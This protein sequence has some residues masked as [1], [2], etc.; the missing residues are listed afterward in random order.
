MPFTVT[1][2]VAWYDP[3]RRLSWREGGEWPHPNHFHFHESVVAAHFIMRGYHVLRDCG[4]TRDFDSGRPLSVHSTRLLHDVVGS[5][6]TEF[7]T[8]E[9]A[10]ATASGTGEPDLFVFR[11]EHPNDPKYHYDDPRLWFFV[12]VKGPEDVVSEDQK[13]FWHK[14]AE[15]FGSDRIRLF[16]TCPHGEN[17]EPEDVEY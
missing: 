10:E 9:L 5:E 3:E 14:V 13:A 17:F 8:G 15:R 7:M 12:E 16:R 1:E 6:A 4:C 2:E 11:E